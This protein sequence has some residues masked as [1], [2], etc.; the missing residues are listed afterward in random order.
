MSEKSSTEY[1]LIA[2]VVVSI[3]VSALSYMS[4]SSIAKN[5]KDLGDSIDDLSTD[6]SEGIADVSTDIESILTKLGEEPIVDDDGDDEEPPL[7]EVTIKMCGWSAADAL[8]LEYAD[9]FMELYPNVKIEYKSWPSNQY[10]EKIMSVL[11]VMPEEAD[12]MLVDWGYSRAMIQAGYLTDIDGMPG[13]SQL[14]AKLRS[15]AKALFIVEDKLYGLPY[16]VGEYMCFWNKEHFANVGVTE[17]PETW[18]EF[19]EIAV[20]MKNQ[21]LVEYPLM[22]ALSYSHYGAHVDWLLMS[23]SYGGEDTRLFGPPPTYEPL[24]LEPDSPGYKALQMLVDMNLKYEI[25]DPATFE[26]DTFAQ[27]EAGMAGLISFIIRASSHNIDDLNLPDES[28]TAGQWDIFETPESGYTIVRGGYFA[29]TS[30][31]MEEKDALTQE[32]AWKWLQYVGSA[33]YGKESAINTKAGFGYEELYEDEDLI[34]EWS[35]Y[36]TVEDYRTVADR[37]IAVNVA[38]NAFDSVWFV[39][40]RL[41]ANGF[42]Q[43]AVMGKIT[44]EEALESLAEF[45][46]ELVAKYEG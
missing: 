6:I 8:V 18:E 7:E 16:F 45:T 19:C 5:T 27:C 26:T 34:A 3:L 30:H 13:A 35:K 33:E 12:V 9:R 21:G 40:W 2:L 32:W 24:F 38:N 31:L 14:K 23:V 29:L 15:A 44:V 4:I 41:P 43:D 36:M 22:P 17:P 37:A 1:I 20:G 42:I 46:A 10:Y 25:L 39:E 11:T 28:A